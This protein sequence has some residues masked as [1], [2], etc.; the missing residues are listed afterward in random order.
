MPFI[1]LFNGTRPL[2]GKVAL[3]VDEATSKQKVTSITQFV[4]SRFDLNSRFYCKVW[5]NI[6]SMQ[7]LFSE[8]SID[9]H[10]EFCF[11]SAAYRFGN[12]EQCSADQLHQTEIRFV[13]RLFKNQLCL[14]VQPY[15]SSSVEVSPKSF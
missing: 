3:S 2:P 6:S 7:P 15:R 14:N 9:V 11:K 12:T 10:G 4:L 13:W 8:V 5:T 1:R